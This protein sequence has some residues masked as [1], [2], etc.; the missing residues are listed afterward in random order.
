MDREFGVS[1]CK[2]LRLEWI[3]S[4]VL[5]YSTGNYTQSFGIDHVGRQYEK[6][7]VY[8]CTTGSLCYTVEISTTL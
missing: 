8:I 4:E 6:K 2:L 1:R 7:N 5:W 3:S